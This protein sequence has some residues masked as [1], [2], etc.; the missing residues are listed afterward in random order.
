MQELVDA[1]LPY[2]LAI[3]MLSGAW[4]NL[5]LFHGRSIPRTDL[6]VLTNR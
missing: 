4:N 5:C 3:L 2:K 1:K 6:R